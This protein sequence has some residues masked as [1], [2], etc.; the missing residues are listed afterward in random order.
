MHMRFKSKKHDGVALY[1]KFFILNLS[2]A[3]NMRRGSKKSLLGTTTHPYTNE[4]L[5]A[6]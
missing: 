6:N 4:N 1:D 5:N 2:L 3:Q